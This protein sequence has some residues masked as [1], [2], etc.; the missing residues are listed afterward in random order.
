MRIC[1]FLRHIPGAMGILGGH[2][3]FATATLPYHGISMY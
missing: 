2:A 3:F 1:S